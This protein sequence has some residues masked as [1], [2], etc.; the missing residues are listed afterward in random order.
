MSE[1]V[2]KAVE[3]FKSGYNCSQSVFAAYADLFGLERE[4]ALKVSA[5]LGGGCGRQRELCGAVSGAAMI[6]GLKFG[7]VDGNDR[8][9]KKLCYEKVREFTAEF[10]KTN[11]SIVC[12]ELLGIGTTLES[13]QPDER[14]QQYYQNA[15]A[16]KSSATAQGHWKKLFFKEMLKLWDAVATALTAHQAATAA[17]RICTSRATNTARSKR[18]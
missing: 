16:R 15:R 8:E 5:G 7:S 10:K 9:G 18:L 3:L 12:R 4:T 11:P 13:A 6:I 2:E 17:S 14:N 1:R